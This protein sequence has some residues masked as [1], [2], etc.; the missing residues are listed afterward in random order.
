[1][2]EWMNILCWA[3][4]CKSYDEICALLRS[5]THRR[6]LVCYRRFETTYR[7]HLPGPS[8]SKR[9]FLFWRYTYIP[10]WTKRQVLVILHPALLTLQKARLETH[11]STRLC[12][13]YSQPGCCTNE[14]MYVP[15][16]G[17]ETRFP[18]LPVPAKVRIPSMLSQ[19]KLC[20]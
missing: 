8:N 10:A 20:R 18:G 1:M 6:M 2:N 4:S 13:G 11:L 14:K 17:I 5:L 16:A 15:R 9:I 7:S 19:L 12:G 3:Q